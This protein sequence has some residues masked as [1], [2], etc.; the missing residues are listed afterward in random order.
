MS[1]DEAITTSDEM[2]QIDLRVFQLSIQLP[3]II[4]QFRTV[5]TQMKTSD[6]SLEDGTRKYTDFI[7]AIIQNAF[8]PE[9]QQIAANQK[10]QKQQKE[11]NN[12][13]NEVITTEEEFMNCMVTYLKNY[14]RI[15]MKSKTVGVHVKNI[16]IVVLKIVALSEKLVKIL[17]NKDYE[18]LFD[19]VKD[20]SIYSNYCIF[21]ERVVNL[22]PKARKE[23]PEIDLVTK[24]PEVKGLNVMDYLIKPVQHITK[25]PLFLNT[26][27]NLMDGAQKK[28][29]ERLFDEVYDVLLD[30]N[31]TQKYFNS[32][33]EKEALL[34]KLKWKTD[35]VDLNN[36]FFMLKVSVKALTLIEKCAYFPMKD[37]NFGVLFSRHVVFGKEKGSKIYIEKVLNNIESFESFDD[38]LILQTADSTVSLSFN[39]KGDLQMF[40]I[41][42]KEYLDSVSPNLRLR[43]TQSPSVENLLSIN[44]QRRPSEAGV[45]QHIK[46]SPDCSPREI[47]KRKKVV[48]Q[49]HRTLTSTAT[50][51]P[52]IS[53]F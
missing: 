51:R 46:L 9:V 31:S 4:D 22:L 21:Y 16:E 28:L 33:S 43:L 5:L 50:H 19:C 11:V 10:K 40:N 27:K 52:N 23:I 30:N 8:T 38:H 20:L 14:G 3:D 25:Y 12:V 36:E 6:I 32:E 47:E 42:I 17:R 7:N 48:K 45:E 2:G 29:V 26:L 15:L 34:P 24:N 53:M 35:E 44:R 41:K 18:K 39:E 37:V 13:L 1:H 49:L